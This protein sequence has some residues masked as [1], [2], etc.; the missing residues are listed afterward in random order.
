[1]SIQTEL[2]QRWLKGAIG[3]VGAHLL[4]TGA[5]GLGKTE[6]VR[7]LIAEEGIAAR[8]LAVLG[9]DGDAISGADRVENLRLCMHLLNGRETQVIVFDEAD[10]AFVL[11][12]KRETYA[13]SV[14]NHR[15]ALNRMLEV[16]RPNYVRV[17]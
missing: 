6:W 2:A 3:Q 15:A 11:D 5:P 9:D 7:A 4:V 13:Q 16:G 12:D 10:D 8:E 17:A 14:T 1:M